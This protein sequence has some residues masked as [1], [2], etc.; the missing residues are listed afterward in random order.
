MSHSEGLMFKARQM[1]SGTIVYTNWVFN[2]HELNCCLEWVVKYWPNYYGHSGRAESGDS[3]S[4]F[5]N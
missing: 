5:K 2:F 4:Q 3:D 1:L